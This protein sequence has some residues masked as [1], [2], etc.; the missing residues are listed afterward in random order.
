MDYKNHEL[1]L[2]SKALKLLEKSLRSEAYEIYSSEQ[3]INYLRLL[4]EHQEREV[5]A[6]LLLDN[7]HRVIDCNLL[8]QGTINSVKVYP[9]EIARYA[10]KHNAAAIICAHNH[11]SGVAEPSFSDRTIIKQICLAMDLIGIST[12][13]HI[14]IGHGDA[15]SFAER[16]WI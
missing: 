16:G 10:L 13:D 8:F 7:K 5:F 3:T 14:I 6:T 9:R 15:V 1:H 12:L 4:L 2:I 11:P